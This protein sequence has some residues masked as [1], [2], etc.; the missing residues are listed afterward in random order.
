MN[1]L[2]IKKILREYIGKQVDVDELSNI[3]TEQIYQ[4]LQTEFPKFP[5]DETYSL[6][7]LI[8]V[9]TQIKENT[10]FSD[11]IIRIDVTKTNK[12]KINGR[13]RSGKTERIFGGFYQ[14]YLEIEMDTN[15]LNLIKANVNGLISHELN[16]A[17]KTIKIQN[18]KSK[19]LIKNEVMRKTNTELIP[20][21][22]EYPALKEF[23]NMFYLELPEE[24]AARVQ[25]T[26]TELQ[27]INTTNYNDTI[28]ELLK[29]NPLNDAKKMM[30]YKIDNIKLIENVVLN[31]FI[32]TFNE[33]L[34]NEINKIAVEIKIRTR[35]N[36]F[37]NYWEYMIN[38][39]GFILYRKIMKLVA[40]K[41]NT[42]END[43][44]KK[45]NKKTL[46]EITGAVEKIFNTWDEN[47]L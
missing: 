47:L 28:K 21:I 13:F 3:I 30:N 31:Y 40:D 44:L 34:S 38:A 42:S 19:S 4:K 8:N 33:Y 16:H 10:R 29:F 1:Q 6:T 36:E 39:H 17:F 15:D 7:Q 43:L 45:I 27:Y 2:L 32:K 37:F 35:I 22:K 26:A 18:Q 20:I 25:Q 24:R 23:M 14:I 5:L 9:P 41:H 12:K 11:I 46:N